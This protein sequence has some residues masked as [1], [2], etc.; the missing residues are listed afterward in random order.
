MQQITPNIWF[1]RHAEE[2]VALYMSVFPEGAVGKTSRYGKEG[3]EFHR[4]PEGTALTM[5]FS[6]YGESFVALNGGPLFPLNPSV[7]FMVMCRTAEEVDRLW[8]GLREGGSVMMGLDRYP[9]STRYGWL[10][11]RFG[12]SWQLY[13]AA[14]DYAG[15]R[16]VPTLMFTGA[17]C[18]RAEEA[19]GFYTALFEDS[20]MDGILHYG[21]GDHDREGLVK[22]AQFV[23]RNYMLMAMD[24][25]ADHGFTFNEAVSLIV[26]CKNQAEVDRYWEAL[27][28]DG[29][30]ESQCGWLKDKFGVS[31]QIVPEQLYALMTQPDKARAAKVMK[32]MLRMKKLVV[33]D[34][35]AAAL[36]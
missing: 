32:A 10:N 13:L 26:H 16:V 31:W 34:L 12:V 14:E 20:K 15:Q 23:V 27:V 24:S 6:L 4:M 35:E 5:E 36:S 19:I 21:A 33:A 8:N 3:F 9:W 1:D 11:D 18:G 17:R 2:A 29:G 7:S 22:H 30:A 25:S 28:A